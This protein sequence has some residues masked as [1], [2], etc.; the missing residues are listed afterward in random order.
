VQECD[1]DLKLPQNVQ[2]PSN[3][4]QRLRQDH[5]KLIDLTRKD[6]EWEFGE[7]QGEAMAWIKDVIVKSPTL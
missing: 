1:R 3:L 6:I 7:E 2:H 5:L 4:H